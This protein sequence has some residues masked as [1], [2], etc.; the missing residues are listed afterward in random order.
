[1]IKMKKGQIM[2][3]SF[4]LEYWIDDSWFVGRL[5]EIPGV[6]SQGQTLHELKTNIADA[7]HL[8]SKTPYAD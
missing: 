1:M 8:K 3:K 7:Y 6:F 5:K 4:T 2:S